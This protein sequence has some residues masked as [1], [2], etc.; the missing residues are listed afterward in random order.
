MIRRRHAPEERLMRAIGLA[1]LATAATVALDSRANA[2]AFSLGT[3]WTAAG[4]GTPAQLMVLG[5]ETCAGSLRGDTLRIV[6][7]PQHGKLKVTG[8]SSYSYTP[9]RAY[10]GPDSFRVSTMTSG[11]MVIGTVIVGVQ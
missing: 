7:P 11:G 4:E 1:M 5:S 9:N 8:P 2:C 3:G 6:A 10:R